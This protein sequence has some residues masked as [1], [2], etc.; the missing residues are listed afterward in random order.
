ME[1][2]NPCLLPGFQ[3]GHAVFIDLQHWGQ[4]VGSVG[5]WALELDHPGLI[6]SSTTYQLW[7]VRQATELLC[8]SVLSLVKY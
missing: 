6:S 3:R 7:D 1:S 2:G 8:A 5:G 4:A